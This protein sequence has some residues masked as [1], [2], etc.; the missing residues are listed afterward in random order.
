MKLRDKSLPFWIRT[1]GIS[2]V[3]LLVLFLSGLTIALKTGIRLDKFSYGNTT[4]TD[5]ILEWDQKLNLNATSIS[6]KTGSYSTPKTLDYPFFRKIIRR[7]RFF[8]T[9]FSRISI[10][11]ITLNGFSA[12]FYY[13]ENEPGSLKI[14]T[15]D[16]MFSSG[17]SFDD[18]RLTFDIQEFRTKKYNSIATGNLVIDFS[19]KK[20]FAEI[21]ADIA[22][23]LPI[24]LNIQA[25]DK[26]LSFTGHG[27]KVIHTIKPIVDLFGID[28]HISQW[29]VD[30][31]KTES[32]KLLTMNGSFPYNDPARLLDTF[33]AEAAATNCNY[34]FEQSLEPIHADTV[35]VQ[36]KKGVLNLFPEGTVF[37]GQ[38]AGKS[39]LD[40]NFG[41]KDIVLTA[42]IKAPVMGN[43]DILRL[44][45]CYNIKLPFKQASGLTN[46]QLDLMINLSK[47]K[48]N[49][50]GSFQVDQGTFIYDGNTY[51]VSDALVTL[52]D[53]DLDIKKLDLS[54]GS[55]FDTDINGTMN[56]FSGMGDLEILLNSFSL[57]IKNKNLSLNKTIRPLKLLYHIQ[58]GTDSVDIGPS[59]WIF[60][61]KNVHINKLSMP[62]DFSHYSG[63][64]PKTGFTISNM[65][66][67]FISGTFNLKQAN[68]KLRFDVTSFKTEFL[69][70]QDKNLPIH[71][72]YNGNHDIKISGP[73]NWKTGFRK[74][75]LNPVRIKITN[76]LLKV[77]ESA[78]HI[79]DHIS[80]SIEGSHDF[81]TGSGKFILYRME[82]SYSDSISHY[83]KE[84]PLEIIVK[85]KTSKTTASI[86]ELDILLTSVPGK[87]WQLKLRN[88]RKISQ[89]SPFLKALKL[90]RG[91][92]SIQSRD[93][94][95]PIL[96]SG[97]IT[98]DHALF[99]KNKSPVTHYTFQGRY[100]KNILS[101]RFNDTL[102]LQWSDK[103]YILSKNLGYSLPGIMDFIRDCGENRSVHSEPFPD[104]DL[105]AENSSLFLG[106]ENF[107]LAD[108]L[109]IQNTGKI[110]TAQMKHHGGHAEFI[111]DKDQF[112]LDGKN[113][114]D[115]FMNTLILQSRFNGGLMDFTAEGTF[116]EFSG[117]I[118]IKETVLK[119]YKQMNN[120][121]AAI[122]TIPS[123]VTFSHP[124]YHADGLPIKTLTLNYHYAKE[125]YHINLFDID[126]RELDISGTGDVDLYSQ[127]L[128]M[129][130]SMITGF[131]TSISK[132][133]LIGYILVGDKKY[134]TLSMTL[135]GDISN[136]DV[137]FKPFHKN[138]K[139]PFNI[140]LRTLSLPDYLAKKMKAINEKYKEDHP[141]E[142][143]TKH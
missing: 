10:D 11:K 29:I 40:L 103:L 49:A 122:N 105:I 66:K 19:K 53:S 46:S 42:Y 59:N 37:Y 33:Y 8:S 126:S 95:I 30:Y 90:K 76:D 50:L 134:P 27:T 17:I 63:E 110:T 65:A 22:D 79:K 141:E 121:L 77:D 43:D 24:S 67:G 113:F 101:A 137:Q 96:F 31:H 44:L 9:W 102:N 18:P 127:T 94:A 62:F 80:S 2:I 140:F 36:F 54:Y 100:N 124:Q 128:N 114:D 47:Q 28:H 39:W 129:D 83:T 55:V 15:E 60:D 118:L 139:N 13:H 132:I 4:V 120:I 104:I 89:L 38:N 57:D 116:S 88:L 1:T 142:P 25:D 107:A 70:S 34:T 12:S 20:I 75:S 56:T 111:L 119:D 85:N 115:S 106:N 23:T 91:N 84:K 21:H 130:I 93:N 14:N 123:L 6:L 26:N 86:P 78:F 41:S 58:K 73:S 136:P 97:S 99:I 87:K 68:T 52:K 117:D 74:T 35:F 3:I 72:T 131:K 45:N 71:Y 82:S 64:L 5:F 143:I 112:I 61:K 48:V 16:L 98:S 138:S 135:T 125:L 51:Q 69:E 92:L 109:K 108:Q 7:T 81:K 32:Y 133:P